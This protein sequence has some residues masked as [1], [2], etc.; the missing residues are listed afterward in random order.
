LAYDKTI[1]TNR[2]VERPRTYQFVDNG[3]GT[4]TLVPAEGNILS[5][6]TPIVADNMN[7][8]ENALENFSLTS[9]IVEKGQTSNG[10]YLKFANGNQI[11]WGMMTFNATT[12]VKGSLYAITLP[13]K[14]LPSAFSH[15]TYFVSIT[16][17]FTEA[18]G[19][20]IRTRSTDFF[21]PR[22]FT[23]SEIVDKYVEFGY[24]CFGRWYES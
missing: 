22:V 16:P 23:I 24:F 1:W 17:Y 7:K 6:G 12:G 20:D 21:E 13:T 19:V 4:N 18:V 14:G 10:H 3:D 15:T 11:C 9:E 8:I 5:E 2:E